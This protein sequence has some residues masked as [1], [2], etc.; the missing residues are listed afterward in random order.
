[1]TNS[2]SARII[3]I[4]GGIMSAFHLSHHD[5]VIIAAAD[6]VGRPSIQGTDMKNDNAARRLAAALAISKFRTKDASFL[7]PVYAEA[8]TIAHAGTEPSPRALRS[9]WAFAPGGLSAATF[10][11]EQVSVAEATLALLIEFGERRGRHTESDINDRRTLDALAD[12]FRWDRDDHTSDTAAGKKIGVSHTTI[13][14]RRKEWCARVL[15]KLQ[16]EW[17]S[18]FGLPYDVFISDARSCGAKSLTDIAAYLTARRIPTPSGCGHS[19]HA[20][21]VSRL[22][23]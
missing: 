18:L 6:L 2:D 20:K 5:Y 21:Q 23:A 9:A 13:G 3:R 12:Q 10:S 17:P 19:W 22:A 14:N 7:V 8:R 1:L 4:Y 16:A 11:A 15:V